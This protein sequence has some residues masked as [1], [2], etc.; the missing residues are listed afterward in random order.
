L[1]TA[2]DD[3]DT[4]RALGEKLANHYLHESW[5]VITSMV[6]PRF[7]IH[8]LFTRAYYLDNGIPTL[9]SAIKAVKPEL[10]LVLDA[11]TKSP[12]ITRD[13]AAQIGSDPE[14]VAAFSDPYVVEGVRVQF[15]VYSTR[16]YGHPVHPSLAIWSLS[17]QGDALCVRTLFTCAYDY[18]GGLTTLVS[19]IRTSKLSKVINALDA[20][21][22]K[23][24]DGTL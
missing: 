19:A 4:W 7:R 22:S 18:D 24:L 12:W 8:S 23:Y 1:V 6:N 21:C 14:L 2:L 15:N 9:F 13:I 16:V 17:R 11:P 10:S 3:P 5:D 20:A